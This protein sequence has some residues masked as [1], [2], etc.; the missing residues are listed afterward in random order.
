MR[1]E[2]VDLLSRKDFSEKFQEDFEAMAQDAFQRMDL[3]LDLRM[4][5]LLVIVSPEKYLSAEWKDVWQA[6]KVGF[7]KVIGGSMYFRTDALLFCEKKL[8]I[9]NA[10]IDEALREEHSSGGHGGVEK[11]VWGFLSRYHIALDRKSLIEKT[12]NIL[13]GCR[14]CLLSKPNSS[15]D[16]GLVGSF[17]IPA[18]VNDV[19]FID[20]TEVDAFNGFDYVMSIVDGLSRFA[21]FVP[22]KKT[23]TG[24][25]AFKLLFQ[26]WISKYGA[27]REVYTD[28][29]VRF[30]STNGFWQAAM[31]RYSIQVKFSAPRHPQS[32]GLCERIQRSFKQVMR[33]LMSEQAGR[34]WVQVVPLATWVLNNQWYAG[35]DLSPAELFLGRP[36]WYPKLAAAETEESPKQ[37]DWFECQVKQ[38][39]KAQKNLQAIRVKAMVKR[40]KHRM[41][42]V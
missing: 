17:P 27:P 37:R 40:N 1:N 26:N 4:E 31:R 20:F 16:R 5:R 34:D 35:L 22:T 8:V 41:K 6:L 38:F 24:E 11:T 10:L 28:N 42:A 25:G 23:I 9:P 13:R 30:S 19:V 21:Q 2:L 15:G 39:A 36:G 33:V 7:P 18:L 29:D 3:H 12:K 14:P 32:N